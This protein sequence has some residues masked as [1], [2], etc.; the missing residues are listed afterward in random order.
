MLYY[1]DDDDDD[2]GCMTC[3]EWGFEHRMCKMCPK[4]SAC[5]QEMRPDP[6]RTN[7]EFVHLVT[8]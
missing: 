3:M 7:R 2:D 6:L 4:T 1:D 8:V 5:T